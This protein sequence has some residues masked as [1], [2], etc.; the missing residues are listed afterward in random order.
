VTAEDLRPGD[1]VEY[2]GDRESDGVIDPGEIGWVT[3][4]EPARVS[5]FWRKTGIQHVPLASIRALPPELGRIVAEAPNARIWPL[6]GE[7][8]PPTLGGRPRN[9]YMEQG[10]H[11]DM[12]A[13]VWDQ[14]GKELPSGSRGQAKGKPVLAHSETDRIIAFPHGTAYSLWLRPDDYADA[15]ESGARTLR[16]WTGGSVTDLTKRAGPGWIW[17][18][19]Y[20]NEPLWLQHAYAA[21]GPGGPTD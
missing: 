16:T 19:W 12:V 2:I 15:L 6:L 10:C 9:P 11:P 17:G 3:K 5:A 4:V 7:E 18:R 1:R 20:S 13:R 14:L 8:R 21:V